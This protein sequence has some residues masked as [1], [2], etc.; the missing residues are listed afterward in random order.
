[1]N[2]SEGGSGDPVVEP[3]A[4][5]LVGTTSAGKSTLANAMV[6]RYVIGVG[7][8]ETT[9]GTIDIRWRRQETIVTDTDG[10]GESGSNGEHGRSTSLS[11]VRSSRSLVYRLVVP[12]FR[13]I[14]EETGVVLR[15]T[16]GVLSAS[17]SR[18]M[19]AVTD[20]VSN[21]RVAVVMLNVEDTDGRKKQALV[22]SV[23]QGSLQ[24]GA[25]ILWVISR[26]NAFL[27]DRDPGASLERHLRQTASLIREAG[28][29][30]ALDGSELIPVSP[31][32][33]FLAVALA[34]LVTGDPAEHDLWNHARDD[35]SLHGYGRGLYDRS[36]GELSMVARAHSLRRL[37]VASGAE[38]LD[39]EVRRRLRKNRRS[40]I[41]RNG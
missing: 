35:L 20:G 21:A 5:A 6:G 17:D 30:V 18:R 16:P 11:I 39:L 29:S 2:I 27:R 12:G 28:G 1:M 24:G 4:V 19:T 9:R 3:A 7:V 26:A 13:A 37:W 31:R 23:L 25:E 41:D 10:R 36:V 40:S 8:Q 14:Q 22:R 32:S 15:D 33:A 38:R 34:S